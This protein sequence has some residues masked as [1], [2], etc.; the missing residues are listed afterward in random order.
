MTRRAERL[1][2]E[3]VARE[4]VSPAATAKRSPRTVRPMGYGRVF[5]PARTARTAD[6]PSDDEA[7]AA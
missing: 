2:R 5:K 3:L 7:G 1:I 6:G 4:A